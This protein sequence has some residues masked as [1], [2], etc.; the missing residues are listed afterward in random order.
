MSKPDW[1]LLIIG[2]D[3]DPKDFTWFP[4]DDVRDCKNLM[5]LEGL[6]ARNIY[7]TSRAIETGSAGLFQHLYINAKLTRGKVLHVSD[8]RENE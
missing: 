5:V 1:D 4:A 8:Y 7:L 2:A 6:R 3:E